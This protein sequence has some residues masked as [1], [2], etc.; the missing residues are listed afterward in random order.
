M[1]GGRWCHTIVLNIH[2]PT[3]YKTDDVKDNSYEE[4]ECVFDNFPKY[5]IKIFL[6]DFNA[7][8]G[9]EDIFKLTIGNESLQEISNDNGVRVVNFATVKI[10]QSEVQCSQIPTFTNILEHLQLGKHK[11]IDHIDT[12]AKTFECT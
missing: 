11:Q 1:S 4:L 7:K 6:G 9:R 5:H 2:A 12:Y 3:E 8:V 10:S